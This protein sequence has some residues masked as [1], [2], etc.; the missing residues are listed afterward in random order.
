MTEAAG[1][2]CDA[3]VRIEM[4]TSGSPAE[5]P[6]PELPPPSPEDETKMPGWDEWED[7]EDDGTITPI[8]D[9]EQLLAGEIAPPAT[10]HT[11]RKSS[12]KTNLA[13]RHSVYRPKRLKSRG[14]QKAQNAKAGIRLITDMAGLHRP[15]HQ[16][17]K[18][19]GVPR[20]RFVDLAA[21]RARGK[22][23]LRHEVPA[24]YRR[25][26]Q[27]LISIASAD[28]LDAG[29]PCTLF[30][31]DGTLSPSAA[32]RFQ[33]TSL[34]PG[35]VA[36]GAMRGHADYRRSRGCTPQEEKKSADE[37]W[38]GMDAK[39][40]PVVA[41]AQRCPTPQSVHVLRLGPTPIIRTPSPRRTPSPNAIPSRSGSPRLPL[42]SATMASSS[43]SP[44]RR[45]ETM[46]G[47]AAVLAQENS[48][49]TEEP[50]PYSPP[51]TSGQAPVRYR[52]L[53]PPDHPL[54]TRF[55]L[56]R[57]CFSWSHEGHDLARG[58]Q[59]DRDP[60]TPAG[61]ATSFNDRPA[62]TFIPQEHSLPADGPQYRV[63]RDRRRYEK[64][65]SLLARR[66]D[67]G[68]GDGASRRVVVMVVPA[69]RAAKA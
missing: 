61:H 57:A 42:G 66:V 67:Y 24:N 6:Q 63:E 20:P 50:P 38:R 15:A 5:G 40:Q 13:T 64:K 10:T 37:W 43:Q 39:K 7:D 44:L 32:R 26:P 29:T 48:T 47:K 11:P 49:P 54:H 28:D 1:R 33:Q 65:R 30:E 17:R 59:H 46:A 9:D 4:A 3:A 22:S 8:E 23:D 52:A 53:F 36:S 14:R 16:S 19:P 35:G 60:L 58:G 31:E 27:N 18:S 55:P 25:N 69:E 62:G 68:A 51:H 21:L 56:A 34:S 2:V 12:T 45:G 41:E